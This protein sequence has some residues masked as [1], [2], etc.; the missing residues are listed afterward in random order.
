MRI[1]YFAMETI[2]IMAPLSAD[3]RVLIRILITE[4]TTQCLSN[5]ARVPFY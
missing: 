5:A 4:K 3:D 2:N 1:P